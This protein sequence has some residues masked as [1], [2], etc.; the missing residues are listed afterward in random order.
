MRFF[1]IDIN[2]FF[3]ARKGNVRARKND[4]YCRSHSKQQCA[5]AVDRFSYIGYVA[6]ALF[7]R[8]F[9]ASHGALSDLVGSGN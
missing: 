5:W 9:V 4:P 2:F 7:N 3:R 6:K 8:K 1:E